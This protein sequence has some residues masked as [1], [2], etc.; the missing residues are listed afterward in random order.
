MTNEEICDNLALNSI[1][2]L[3]EN[4]L[5]ALEKVISTFTIRGYK[6]ENLIYTQNKNPNL[7]DIKVSIICTDSQ[8]EKLIKILHNQIN[9]IEIRLIIDEKEHDFS[10]ITMAS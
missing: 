3:V 1:Y 5:G 10:Y 7:F 9:V 6:I 2:L 4:K 8:L